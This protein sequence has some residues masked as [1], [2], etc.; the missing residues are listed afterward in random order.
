MMWSDVQVRHNASV[1]IRNDVV[2]RHNVMLHKQLTT[3]RWQVASRAYFT[4]ERHLEMYPWHRASR[5]RVV[6]DRILPVVMHNVT[7]SRHISC[8][9]LNIHVVVRVVAVIVIIV[10]FRHTAACLTRGADCG[11]GS[12]AGSTRADASG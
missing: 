9:L 12:S 4:V 1:I 10:A 11:R 7:A 5:K 3:S 8:H 2:T 6:G